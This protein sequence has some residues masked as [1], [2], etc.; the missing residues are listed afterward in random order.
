LREIVLVDDAIDRLVDIVFGAGPRGPVLIVQDETVITRHGAPVKPVVAAAFVA[1]GSPTRVV[2]LHDDVELHTTPDHIATVRAALTEGLTVIALGSGTVTDITKHAVHGFETAYPDSPLRLFVV[3]TAN[4]VCAFTSSLAVVTID[5]VKRTLPSRLADA[6]ILDTQI[7]AEAP[8]EYTDGG[9]GDASVAAVSFADYRLS[10]L[11]GFTRWEPLA[12]ELMEFSRQRFLAG[13]P[14]LGQ[15]DA[16]GM[17]ALALDLAATG[18]CMTVA[19]E[20]APVSG[21]EHVTSHTLDM[22]AAYYGRPVGNHGSQC[23]LASIL[24]LIAWQKLLTEADLSGLDPATIDV[25]AE[26]AKV[27]A[28][29]GHIDKDGLA[30]R[31]CWSDYAAKIHAWQAGRDQILAFVR[32]WPQ[33]RGDLGRFTAEPEAYVAAL[34]ATG[35]PLR[36]ADIPTG[37]DETQARWAFTNARLM[38][39]RTSVAD[40]LGFAGYWTEEFIAAVFDTYHDLIRRYRPT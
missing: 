15:R 22:A 35:H 29:F 26:Q 25:T 3:Q 9:V 2:Q 38:R 18:L 24:S 14:T 6:L 12:F 33:H 23:A 36:F 31:E 19:G 13:F 21:L 4:S 11:L 28:A 34:A 20:S 1:A 8:P 27:E 40:L 37:L 17:S 10:H 30:W 39:Q 5:G 32:Q 7:L 16:E